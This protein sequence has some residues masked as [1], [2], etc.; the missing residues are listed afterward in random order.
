MTDGRKDDKLTLEERE[1]ALRS[2][3]ARQ[4][5]QEI[6]RYGATSDLQILK[7]IKF[8]SLELENTE[9]M[10]SICAVVDFGG[11]ERIDASGGSEVGRKTNKIE[12]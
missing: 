5:V 8:L 11:E 2:L 3:K 4:I 6:V 10:R 7:I 9:M 12:L 1:E